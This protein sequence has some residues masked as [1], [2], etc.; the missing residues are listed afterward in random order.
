LIEMGALDPEE[1]A[2][3]RDDLAQAI[4]EAG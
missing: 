4:K 3:T 2:A 1:A